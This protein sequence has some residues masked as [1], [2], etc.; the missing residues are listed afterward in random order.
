MREEY[1]AAA[2]EER[3]P[4]PWP[5]HKTIWGWAK[6]YGWQ[7]RHYDYLRDN[8]DEIVLRT[9]TKHWALQEMVV[10]A[11]TALLAG[12]YNTDPLAANV[13]HKVSESILKTAGKGIWGANGAGEMQLPVGKLR[14]EDD[15]DEED[16]P[17]LVEDPIKRAARN[18]RL[19][20]EEKKGRR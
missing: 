4:N 9:Q 14:G 6:K 3:E 15:I 8:F 16:N 18:R 10:D 1:Q 2:V 17:E 19:N 12:A 7:A 20:I 5:S 11:Q 13:I